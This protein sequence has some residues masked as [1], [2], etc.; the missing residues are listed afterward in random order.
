MF[1]LNGK[2]LALD[3]AFTTEDGR[4]F[5]ANWLRLSTADERGAIG[6]TEEPDQVQYY[7]QRFYWGPDLPKDHEQLVEQWTA[8]V[9]QTASS[10]LSQT[11]WYITR[12]SETGVAAPQS[13]LN[14]RSDIRARSNA[15]EALL[16]ATASTEELAEYITSPEFNAWED[17]PEEQPVVDSEFNVLDFVS[18][19]A[20]FTDTS[21]ISG[22]GE[23]TITFE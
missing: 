19:N 5:P 21:I 13:V 11:D 17:I 8:Q 12:D 14:R 2:P 16:A 10:L 6:I 18:T 3:R 7:D 1:I 22:S 15:K 9:K 4:Q 23:D 20:T